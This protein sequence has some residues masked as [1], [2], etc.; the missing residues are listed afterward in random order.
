MK[1][2]PTITNKYINDT[3]VLP[4]TPFLNLNHT[5][6]NLKTVHSKETCCTSIQQVTQT[7]PP[8][9]R[10]NKQ[11]NR[12]EPDRN[13]SNNNNTETKIDLIA[14]SQICVCP[15]L[16]IKYSRKKTIIVANKLKVVLYRL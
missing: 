4:I 10:N 3:I 12:P 8:N 2:P 7:T 1:V 9:S 5:T 16:I 6:I 14:L 13:Q 11:N 15:V